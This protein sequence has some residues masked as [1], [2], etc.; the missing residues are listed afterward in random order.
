[1]FDIVG[2]VDTDHPIPL[3]D[4]LLGQSSLPREG[5]HQVSQ[6]I[7]DAVVAIVHTATDIA[8]Q[9]MAPPAVQHARALPLGPDIPVST[10]LRCPRRRPPRMPWVGHSE[11]KPRGNNKVVIGHEVAGL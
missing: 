7:P 11:A 9:A 2:A 8:D 5:G 1:M 6:P 4:Q 3:R 10:L